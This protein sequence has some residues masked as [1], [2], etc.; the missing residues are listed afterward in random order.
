M[1]SD[2]TDTEQY[3][4]YKALVRMIETNSGIGFLNHDL[5]HPAYILG[6]QGEVNLVAGGDSPEKN[7]LFKLF[8]SFEWIPEGSPDLSTWQNFCAFAVDAYNH[9]HGYRPE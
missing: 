9:A 2:P 6:K 3:L 8:A 1:I 5:G 7:D 4:I